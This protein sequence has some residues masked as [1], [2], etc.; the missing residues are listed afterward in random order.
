MIGTMDESFG[1]ENDP[2]DDIPGKHCVAVWRIGSDS[3]SNVIKLP[4]PPGTLMPIG[5]D[6]VVTFYEHPRLYDLRTGALLGEWPLDSGKQ[7]G[8]IT[9][10]N[11][12]PPN[13]LQ[14][15]RARFAVATSSAIHV[16]EIDVS[17]LPA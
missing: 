14:S 12:P 6:F 8:S 9:W 16:V 3:Y 1:D 5:S 17:A 10:N 11:L 2:V 13:A 15:A 4:H 7:A